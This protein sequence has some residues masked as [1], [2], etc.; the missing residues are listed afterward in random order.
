MW[1]DNSIIDKASIMTVYLAHFA[2]VDSTS[3]T[4]KIKR[5]HTSA[6]ARNP[7]WP[8]GQHCPQFL[9]GDI[10]VYVDDTNNYAYGLLLWSDMHI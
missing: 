5:M 2:Q 10:T 4:L 3:E 8:R 7:Q 9:R 1:N 6:H